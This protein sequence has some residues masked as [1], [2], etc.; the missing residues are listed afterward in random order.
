MTLLLVINII[1]ID[2][3]VYMMVIMTSEAEVMVA[4]RKIQYGAGSDSFLSSES[5]RRCGFNQVQVPFMVH[6]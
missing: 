3:V 4:L 5:E 6:R 2:L 1:N